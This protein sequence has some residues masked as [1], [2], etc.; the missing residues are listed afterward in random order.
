M[1]WPGTKQLA[2]HPVLCHTMRFCC[3]ACALLILKIPHLTVCCVGFKLHLNCHVQA[4]RML[5][6]AELRLT[7]KTP[8]Q[9]ILLLSV[10]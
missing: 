3:L 9:A 2:T 6:K 8:H 10:L 7:S 4:L 5:D 1:L